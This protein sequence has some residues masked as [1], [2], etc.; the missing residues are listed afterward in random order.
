LIST[1]V[2]DDEKRFSIPSAHDNGRIN[3]FDPWRIP[4]SA[5]RNSWIIISECWPNSAKQVIKKCWWS[6]ESIY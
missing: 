2:G 1:I 6:S 5:K 3:T 4:I